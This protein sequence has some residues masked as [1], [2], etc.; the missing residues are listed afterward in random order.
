MVFSQ[1]LS[2]GAEPRR[3]RQRMDTVNSPKIQEN[4]GYENTAASGYHGPQEQVLII[5]V[6]L[7][8]SGKVD[9]HQ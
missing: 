1:P 7:I 3:S 8:G 2:S 6:G 9:G 4:S 5:L